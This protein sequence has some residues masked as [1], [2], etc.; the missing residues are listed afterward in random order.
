MLPIT[1]E[2]KK[3]IQK[4]ESIEERLGELKDKYTERDLSLGF[5]EYKLG[6]LNFQIDELNGGYK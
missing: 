3:N 2:L 5:K 1:A 6:L 4:Y